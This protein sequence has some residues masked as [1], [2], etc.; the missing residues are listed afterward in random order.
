ML[1][2]ILKPTNEQNSSKSNQVTSQTKRNHFK[3]PHS[4]MAMGKNRNLLTTWSPQ[5]EGC[6]MFGFRRRHFISFQLKSFP[7][8]SFIQFNFPIF[9]FLSFFVGEFQFRRRLHT[10]K[11]RLYFFPYVT[12]LLLMSPRRDFLPP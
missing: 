12:F 3:T 9:P 2:N 10:K 8:A 6:Q 11:L 5:K 7:T 1:V 4:L